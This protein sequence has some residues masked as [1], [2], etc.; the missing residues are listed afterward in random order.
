MSKD[1]NR[2][3]DF[4]SHIVPDID[5][6]AKSIDMAITMLMN[7]KN[8]GVKYIAASSHFIYGELEYSREEYEKK[9]S[10]IKEKIKDIDIVPAMEVYINTE[11]RSL[12]RGG[13]IWTINDTKYMLVELPLNDFPMYTEQVFYDL[14]LEG[15]VPILAHPERNRAIIKNQDL[16]ENLIEQGALAQTNSGSLTGMFGSTVKECAEKLVKRNLVHMIGSDGHNDNKRTTNILEGR[17]R[18][19]KINNELF[20]WIED[21]EENI[22]LNKDIDCLP[23]LKNEKKSFFNFFKKKN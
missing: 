20:R 14:R 18:I 2:I 21:N 12:Y 13:K 19:K 23:I 9:M 22:I 5:D 6:G 3:V 16:L 15:I 7:S 1:N 10:N 11:L 4:H 8:Q 17:N